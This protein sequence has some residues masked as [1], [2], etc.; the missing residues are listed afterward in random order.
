MSKRESLQQMIL[1]KLRSN[2]QKNC[3]EPL[4]APYTKI[5][6]QWLKEPNLRPE[7]IKILEKNIGSNFFDIGYSNFF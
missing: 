2:M 6:R 5:N 1:G 4:F 3:N 7:N